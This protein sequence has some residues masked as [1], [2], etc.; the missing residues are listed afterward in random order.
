MDP[1]LLLLP[2]VIAA[3]ALA[4]WVFALAKPD[5]RAFMMAQT[6]NWWLPQVIILPQA[7]LCLTLLIG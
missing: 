5:L 2:A 1:L 6:L 3:L 4:G 7:V